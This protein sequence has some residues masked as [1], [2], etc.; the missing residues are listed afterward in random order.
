MFSRSAETGYN[1]GQFN[2]GYAYY[3]GNVIKQDYNK[4]VHWFQKAAL[5]ETPNAYYFLGIMNYKGTGIHKD[6]LKAED[7]FLKAAR[8]DYVPSYAML[9]AINGRPVY[10]ASSPGNMTERAVWWYIKAAENDKS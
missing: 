6:L 10:E 8:M 2:L 3:S 9:A 5:E 7:Y 1:W 4:A